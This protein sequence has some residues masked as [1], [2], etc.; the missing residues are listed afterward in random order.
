MCPADGGLRARFERLTG[1]RYGEECGSLRQRVVAT[2][3][4]GKQVRLR[5]AVT[6]AAT[7]SKMR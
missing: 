3:Y 1:P 4:R 6:L 5:A 7:G 2:P